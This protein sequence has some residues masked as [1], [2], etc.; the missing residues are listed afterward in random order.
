MTHTTRQN[1][2]GRKDTHT[3]FEGTDAWR[4]WGGRPLQ[5]GAGGDERGGVEHSL[6]HS[7]LRGGVRHRI[8]PEELKTVQ[9]TWISMRHDVTAQHSTS[10]LRDEKTANEVRR[11]RATAHSAG[12]VARASPARPARLAGPQGVVGENAGI[13]YAALRLVENT[14]RVPGTA[15]KFKR[16]ADVFVENTCCAFSPIGGAT[17]ARSG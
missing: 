4:G 10:A 6:K 7:L 11:G 3:V 5:R 13:P 14:R 8:L 1:F 16:R 17:V 2:S 12:R 9:Y 15:R